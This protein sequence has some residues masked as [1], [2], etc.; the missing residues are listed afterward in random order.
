MVHF[1]TTLI[2]CFALCS[3]YSCAS[4]NEDVSH[5]TDIKYA[6]LTSEH[7]PHVL[8]QANLSSDKKTS[9]TGKFRAFTLL[10][11]RNKRPTP[12]FW[13]TIS[14][15]VQAVLDKLSEITK[16][17]PVPTVRRYLLLSQNIERLL[18]LIMANEKID[19]VNTPAYRK[20]KRRVN[21]ALKGINK[22][23]ESALV[24]AANLIYKFIMKLK[25]L[26]LFMILTHEISIFG[27]DGGVVIT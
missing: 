14:R 17:K 16:P 2:I 11:S 6:K 8:K 26:G 7:K 27:P 9:K 25:E 1:S 4:N 12:R 23:D 19:D 24:A 10:R 20:A 5:E 22:K 21:K 3:T 18:K 13:S 15:I